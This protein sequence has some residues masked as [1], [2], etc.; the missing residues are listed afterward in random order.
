MLCWPCMRHSRSG[1][2][3]ERRCEFWPTSMI[4]NSATL[5]LRVTTAT[6]TAHWPESMTR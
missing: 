5:A 4:A 2:T 6:A 1:V 3:V